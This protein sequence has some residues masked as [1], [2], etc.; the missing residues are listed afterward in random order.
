METSPNTAVLVLLLLI[1]A[2]VILIGIF[3][4]RKK[5]AAPKSVPQPTQTP[6]STAASSEKTS[7]QKSTGMVCPGCGKKYPPGQVY[8]DECGALLKET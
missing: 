8:C 6:L 1:A 5:N 4:F 2:A 3:A 7:P